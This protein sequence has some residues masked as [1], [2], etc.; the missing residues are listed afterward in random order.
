MMKRSPGASQS[1][2]EQRLFARRGMDGSPEKQ[3]RESQR[4][5]GCLGTGL[6]GSAEPTEARS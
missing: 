4:E 3:E 6:G 5:A 1:V 2:Q